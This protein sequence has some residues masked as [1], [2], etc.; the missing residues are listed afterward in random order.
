MVEEDIRDGSI[1]RIADNKADAVIF[2]LIAVERN[3]VAVG[4]QYAGAAVGYGVGGKACAV[5]AIHADTR[6]HGI[7]YA[8]VSDACAGAVG[9][10]DTVAADAWLFTIAVKAY[11]VSANRE[12]CN[13]IRVDAV[14]GSEINRVAGDQVTVAAVVGEAI[15]ADAG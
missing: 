3:A 4:Y 12:V 5:A 2:E 14:I 15:G 9:H 8:V 7:A 13:I 10:E 11:E 1:L 6:V